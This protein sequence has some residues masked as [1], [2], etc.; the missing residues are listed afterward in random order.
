MSDEDLEAMAWKVS[1]TV[2][3]AYR[4]FYS[5]GETWEPNRTSEDLAL[6]KFQDGYTAALTAVPQGVGLEAALKNAIDAQESE[7]DGITTHCRVCGHLWEKRPREH[8]ATCW[9]GVAEIALQSAPP[10]PTPAT[11]GD[12]LGLSDQMIAVL[13]REWSESAYAASWLMLDE[14]TNQ[15]FAEWVRD[16]GGAIED[17]ERED[18][19]RLRASLNAVG[20]TANPAPDVG[21]REALAEVRVRADR[22]FENYT[23]LAAASEYHARDTLSFI[24]TL[25]AEPTG[26]APHVCYG[27]VDSTPCE[28]SVGENHVGARATLAPIE[29]EET[30]D[31]E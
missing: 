28:C 1:P 15:S 21:L 24:R 19:P 27:R 10:S 18:L 8:G 26:G 2:L 7:H 23:P 4:A 30:A 9:V 11:P 12:G 29:G 20:L 14:T 22:Y 17:Y 13:Y 31:A 16:G 5:L 3:S 25:V 6:N